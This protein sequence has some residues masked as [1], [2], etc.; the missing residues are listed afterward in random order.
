MRWPR[1]LPGT[2]VVDGIDVHREIFRTP[3]GSLRRMSTYA[4]T[5]WTTRRR[6]GAV[7]RSHGTQVV[8]VQC[9]SGNAHYATAVARRL[10]L[11]L[12]VTLQG[13]LTM[14]S[15]QVYQRSAFLR[16]QLRTLF[17]EADAITACSSHT[18]NEAIE[19]TGVDPGHRAS[20]VYNGVSIDEFASAVPETRDRPYVLALGRHVREKGF[21]VLLDAFARLTNPARGG[22]TLV[23]AGDGPLRASLT[24]QARRLGIDGL[25]DFAGR[26]D[27][28]RTAALF[29]GCTLFVLPSRHEPMGIVNLEAMAAGRPVLATAVGGVPELIEHGVNGVLVEPDDPVALAAKLEALIGD[30]SL[31]VRLAH[32]GRARVQAFDWPRIA[33]EYEV[34]YE[35]VLPGATTP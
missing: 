27:R 25:V 19:F 10:G 30:E 24:D 6:I 11:P 26:C 8:H 12:V 3:E 22:H 21:D 29:A 28:Q 2:S 16:K 31:R 18:L 7:L 23:I 4:A 35:R 14:D 20:V 17:E 9:V 33:D 34:V 13:E 5:T 15:S 32:V 1:D